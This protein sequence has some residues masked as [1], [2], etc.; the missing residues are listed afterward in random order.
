[1]HTKRRIL[2]SLLLRLLGSFTLANVVLLWVP[3]SPGWLI[4]VLAVGLVAFMLSPGRLLPLAASLTATTIVLEVMVRFGV[5]GLTPYYRPHERLALDTSY[6]PNQRVEMEVPHGDLLAIDPALST[7]LAAPRREVFVT[8]SL[9]YRN[10]RDYGGTRL[11]LVGDSFL[12]GT[13]TTLVDTLKAEHDADA[14]NLSFAS[15]GPLIYADKVRWARRQFGNDTCVVLFFFEGNDFQ[16]VDPVE[17]AQRRA[18]PRE[19]QLAAKTYIQAVRGISEWSKAFL[20]ISTRAGE[21]LRR[22]D[23]QTTTTPDRTTFTRAV[24]NVPVAFLDGYADVVRRPKFDD[25]GFVSGQLAQA[26]PDLV[27]FI[28]DKFR[29]YGPLLDENAESVLPHAQWNYL[30]AATDALGI[31][32]VDLTAAMV[33]RSRE[34]ATQGL[35]TFWPDDTHWNR[36]GEAV[37]ARIF[38]E[39]LQSSAPEKCSAAIRPVSR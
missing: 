26:P 11:V 24:A 36:H 19:L 39:T 1:M 12:V 33:E 14:Y 38:L 13:E 28:P 25:H 30:R 9:G 5:G 7:T 4:G 20:G 2:V 23:D 31:P 22:R 8:D 16:L 15:I 21:M 34:L 6:R 37:A 32:A 17:L 27:F 18:V 3:M 29:V 10:S 35:L